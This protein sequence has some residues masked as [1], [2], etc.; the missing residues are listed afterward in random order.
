QV[1]AKS[2]LSVETRRVPQVIIV[3]VE[4]NN[5]LYLYNGVKELAPL[6]DNLQPGDK[7]LWIQ[8]GRLPESFHNPSA[9]LSIK[10]IDP[11]IKELA[12]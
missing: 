5:K 1:P 6:W 2:E 8:A 12:R 7:L 9:S 3:L 10:G 4:A 11:A